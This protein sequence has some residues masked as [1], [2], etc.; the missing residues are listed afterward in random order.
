MSQT[1]VR[2]RKKVMYL[3]EVTLRQYKRQA[4]SC[5]RASCKKAAAQSRSSHFRS[6]PGRKLGAAYP[7]TCEGC[8]AASAHHVTLI[9]NS[10]FRLRGPCGFTVSQRRNTA[11]PRRTVA[12]PI[13]VILIISH[14]CGVVS[15]QYSTASPARIRRRDT[16]KCLTVGTSPANKERR[17]QELT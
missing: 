8:L 2:C 14:S 9:S 13:R 7:A 12:Q 10:D 4:R 16:Q 1:C 6:P 3:A 17:A 5:V 11:S 15:D